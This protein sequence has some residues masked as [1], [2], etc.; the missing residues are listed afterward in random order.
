MK[1]LFLI[2][3]AKSSW[4]NMNLTDFDRPLNERGHTDAQDMANRLKQKAIAFDKILSSP[5]NRAQTTAKYFLNML[6]VEETKF[7]LVANI[8]DAYE[9]DILK[10][11]QNTSNSVNNLAVFGHN[12]TF[13]ILANKFADNYIM[14]VP[15]C[16]VVSVNFETEVWSDFLNAPNKLVFFDFPKNK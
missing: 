13:T 15:T 12:P 3:H 1:N 16:G 8:Y 7:E 14:N 10:L 9:N 4:E 2:R 11:I 5:A 6:E